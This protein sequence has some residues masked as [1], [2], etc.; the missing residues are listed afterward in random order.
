[1]ELSSLFRPSNDGFSESLENL[2]QIFND[3]LLNELTDKLLNDVDINEFGEFIL[4]EFKQEPQIYS[5]DAETTQLPVTSFNAKSASVSADKLDKPS[6]ATLKALLKSRTPSS[7]VA[8]APELR[9]ESSD[10][11][12]RKDDEV[13]VYLPRHPQKDSQLASLPDLLSEQPKARNQTEG[14]NCVPKSRLI[15]NLLNK[16]SV[17]DTPKSLV[18]NSGRSCFYG[19]SSNGCHR[20]N[21]YNIDTGAPMEVSRSDT[22]PVRRAPHN[23]IEK[24]YRASI[25]GRIDELRSILIPFPNGDSKVNKSAVLRQAIDRIKELEAKNEQLQAELQ[26][27]RS[28]RKAAPRLGSFSHSPESGVCSFEPSPSCGSFTSFDVGNLTPLSSGTSCGSLTHHGNNESGDSAVSSL[29]G[30]SSPDSLGAA[31]WTID[32]ESPMQIFEVRD[33]VTTATPACDTQPSHNNHNDEELVKFPP[34]AANLVTGTGTCGFDS[35]DASGHSSITSQLYMNGDPTIDGFTTQH[36]PTV[37]EFLTADKITTVDP[38]NLLQQTNLRS[39]RRSSNSPLIS[40]K[41]TADHLTSRPAKIRRELFVSSG[42]NVADESAYQL[43]STLPSNS[44]V[45]L[46]PDRQPAIRKLLYTSDVHMNSDISPED[47]RAPRPSFTPNFGGVAARTTLCVVALCLITFDPFILTGNQRIPNSQNLRFSPARRLLSVFTVISPQETAEASHNYWLTWLACVIQWSVAAFLFLRACQKS[48]PSKKDLD[49]RHLAAS[50]SADLHWNK[51]NDALAKSSW[52]LAEQ[53]LWLCLA[54]LDAP[55]VNRQYKIDH[56]ANYILFLHDWLAILLEAAWFVITRTPRWIWTMNVRPWFRRR[57]RSPVRSK[58]IT[59]SERP[60]SLAEIRLRLLELYLFAM[61]DGQ[62]DS[63]CLLTVHPLAWF[64]LLLSCLC[65]FIDGAIQAVGQEKRD[66]VRKQNYT[67][68]CHLRPS[69]VVRHGVTLVLIIS[70]RGCSRISR[71]FAGKVLTVV[72]RL[73]D[74]TIWGRWICNP[75]IRSIFLQRPHDCVCLSESPVEKGS[76]RL[77]QVIQRKLRKHLTTH[78]LRVL[79][80][81]TCPDFYNLGSSLQAL[82]ELCSTKHAEY[83]AAESCGFVFSKHSLC[84]SDALIVK[85]SKALEK[86]RWWAQF[87]AVLWSSLIGAGGNNPGI[88]QSSMSL[89]NALPSALEEPPAIVLSCPHTGELAR[90]LW[91][92]YRAA[93]CNLPP[94]ERQSLACDASILIKKALKNI[95]DRCSSISNHGPLVFVDDMSVPFEVLVWTLIAADT[96]GNIIFYPFMGSKL[97]HREFIFPLNVPSDALKGTVSALWTFRRVSYMLGPERPEWI[98]LKLMYAD[99]LGAVIFGSNPVR[100][101]IRLMQRFHEI[102]KCLPWNSVQAHMKRM[103]A[104]LYGVRFLRYDEVVSSAGSFRRTLL[105]TSHSS[106]SSL[107]V[108]DVQIKSGTELCNDE[109][110]AQSSDS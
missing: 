56:V 47:S 3:P 54:D 41:R 46:Q 21:I 27:L 94:A 74:D 110:I 26:A 108:D 48:S 53:H 81:R 13:G 88:K 1:M 30:Q 70:R 32:L 80:H 15:C 45:E 49:A 23:A 52:S 77:Y 22:K 59:L 72:N 90:A 31:S 42:A 24:R 93:C 8:P 61:D 50:E 100:A 87:T 62:S 83:L 10:L 103:L 105:P 17:T 19:T 9:A 25:N 14:S 29:G 106:K 20:A 58:P 37:A 95:C 68:N 57:T 71:I 12:S 84:N 40:G 75:V 92:T 104:H 66:S 39:V 43:I 38:N 98:R 60:S 6:H 89:D 99:A 65:D 63:S 5:Q 96:L 33:F 101:R 69:L 109:L 102:S 11:M 34:N 44:S 16:P 86:D 82:L 85:S 35:R 79:L 73:P 2:S 76:P 51:A 107:R 36:L 4:D 91:I 64:R 7:C 78:C 28:L 67:V 55:L 97:F 18:T